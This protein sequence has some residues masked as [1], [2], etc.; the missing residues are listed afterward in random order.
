[1]IEFLGK[2]FKS[3]NQ[4]RVD[5]YAKVVKKINELEE[6]VSKLSA[7]EFKDFN[8]YMTP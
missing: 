8:V 1:M 6:D 3:S 2:I 5:G 4:R 7:E